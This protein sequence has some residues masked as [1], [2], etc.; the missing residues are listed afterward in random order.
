M[1]C[2]EVWNFAAPSYNLKFSAGNWKS[3]NAISDSS[4]KQGFN[5]SVSVVLPDTLLVPESLIKS[6]SG[7]CDYYK[8]QD[9]PLTV[10]LH[11]E[12]LNSFI[13]SGSLTALSIGTRIDC[14]NCLAITSSGHLV[15]SLLKEFYEEFGIEGKPSKYCRK[16]G[17]SLR[18]S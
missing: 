17:N 9:F 8:V 1:L 10:L 12:F 11:E 15:L 2:P 18:Y 6:L 5:H 3:P 13:R 7:N 14:D 4:K 16:K